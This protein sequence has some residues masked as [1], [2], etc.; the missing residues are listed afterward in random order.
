MGLRGHL[1]EHGGGG[2]ILCRAQGIYEVCD[3][4]I[5]RDRLAYSAGA[6]ARRD[7]AEY[8]AVASCTSHMMSAIAIQSLNSRA[9]S[10]QSCRVV[11]CQ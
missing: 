3:G 6:A 9:F 7:E 8:N 10:K 11:G 2:G 4:T 5:C 1:P